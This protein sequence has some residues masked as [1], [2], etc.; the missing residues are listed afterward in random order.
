MKSKSELKRM[1]IQTF[2]GW[3]DCVGEGWRS[4]VGPLVEACKAANV[5]IVQVKEKFG[6]LRFYADDCPP[7]IMQMIEDAELAS[8]HT[9][10]WCG[11]TED[12]TTKGGWLKSLCPACHEERKAQYK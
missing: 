8:F 7:A 4:L 2:D 6:G 3:V 10:E 1:E 5:K 9:C 12:V 11:S